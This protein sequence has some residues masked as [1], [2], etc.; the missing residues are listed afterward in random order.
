VNVL[1]RLLSEFPYNYPSLFGFGDDKRQEYS[2]EEKKLGENFMHQK[3]ERIARHKET[4]ERVTERRGGQDI[5]VKHL[6]R[7]Q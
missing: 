2:T 5:P 4:F 1:R 7:R 3:F 6:Y